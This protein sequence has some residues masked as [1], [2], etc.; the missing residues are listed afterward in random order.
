MVVDPDAGAITARLS[1]RFPQL[2]HAVRIRPVE[3]DLDLLDVDAVDTSGVGVAYLCIDDDSAALHA[4]L[5]IAQGLAGSGAVVVV[6]M[7]MANGIGRLLERPDHAEQ[8][9]VFNLFERTMRPE[10][11]LGGT[12][13]ILA[14]AIHQDYVTEQ[15]R[16]G[17]TAAGNPSMVSWERLPSSLKESNRD[18]AAHIGTKLDAIGRGIAPLTDWDAHNATFSDTEIE[19]LAEMEH[20]RWVRERLLDGWTVGGDDVEA[21]RSPHLVAWDELGEDRRGLARSAGARNSGRSRPAGYRIVI[22]GVRD[23][24]SLAVRRSRTHSTRSSNN[25]QLRFRE[26]AHGFKG[27]ANPAPLT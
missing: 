15:R 9:R 1:R 7:I 10:L 26:L 24:V 16:Q 18:Q 6:E 8:V 5:R 20:D 4:G 2:S 14:R 21:K 11:L 22:D 3:V 12:Y 13:E 27:R 25:P 19:R 17:E 23:S